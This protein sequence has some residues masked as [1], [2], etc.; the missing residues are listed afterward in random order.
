MKIFSVLV[1]AAIASMPSCVILIRRPKPEPGDLLLQLPTGLLS[2]LYPFLDESFWE[3]AVMQEERLWALLGGMNGVLDLYR[4]FGILVQVCGYFAS[5]SPGG[6]VEEYR[7][8]RRRRQLLY[9]S[10][11]ACFVEA[12]AHR[13]SKEIPRLHARYAAML[14]AEACTT[15]R[16]LVEQY[17]P[18][19]IENLEGIL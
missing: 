2:A 16:T 13:F 4:C 8:Q 3:F 19:M 14:Y 6:A 17:R 7:A 1:L 10:I 9:I 12:M 15:T 11:L 18:E 5:L